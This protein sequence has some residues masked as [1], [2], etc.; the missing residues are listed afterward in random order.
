MNPMRC[1]KWLLPLWLLCQAG[2]TLADWE[3]VDENHLA[4][5]YI[6]EPIT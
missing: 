1:I 4:V 3:V 2:L 5:V 6:D